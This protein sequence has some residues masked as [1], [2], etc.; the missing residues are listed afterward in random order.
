MCSLW[1][2]TKDTT[3]VMY[4]A[5]LKDGPKRAAKFSQMI[6]ERIFEMVWW[7]GRKWAHKKGFW[8]CNIFLL[9]KYWL[10]VF[11]WRDSWS[12]FF[13]FLSLFFN[14]FYLFFLC[15]ISLRT[16]RFWS[17]LRRKTTFE[18]SFQMA[19]DDMANP[20]LWRWGSFGYISGGRILQSGVMYANILWWG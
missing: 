15:S 10:P 11:I 2:K 16:Q 3:Q 6:L 1:V 18:N 19:W 14:T 9:S 13:L 8:S 4:I 12:F 7:R 20:W 5:K 17:Y